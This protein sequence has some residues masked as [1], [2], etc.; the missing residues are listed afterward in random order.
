M[1]GTNEKDN[2]YNK[3]SANDFDEIL[4]IYMKMSEFMLN[5]RKIYLK[6]CIVSAL[7]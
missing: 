4:S 1:L 7:I 3:R 2:M 5:I 6:N